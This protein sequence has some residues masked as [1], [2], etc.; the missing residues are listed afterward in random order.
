MLIPWFMILLLFTPMHVTGGQIYKWV[1]KHGKVHYG[2][3]PRSENS[4]E[5]KLKDNPR[6]ESGTPG[7]GP[8]DEERREKRRRLLDAFEQERRGKQATAA[9]KA[10]ARKELKKRCEVARQGLQE[11]KDAQ[12][13]YRYDDSGNRVVIS[14]EEREKATAD[15]KRTIEKRCK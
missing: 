7:A 10:E 2:D 9:K 1:D 13:L 5:I 8:T 14:N 12:Y 15:L 11:R 4:E 6:L 3:R